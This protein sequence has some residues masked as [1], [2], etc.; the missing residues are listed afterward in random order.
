MAGVFR[1]HNKFHRNSHH[2]LSNTLN[3]DQGSDPIASEIEPFQGIFY[4]ILTDHERTYSIL[5]NSFEWYSVYSTVYSFSAYWDSIG[6]TY[7]TVNAFSSNWGLGYSAY[8]SLNPVSANFESAYTTVKANSAIWGDPNLL[9]TNRAQE[10]TKSKTF[11]GYDLTIKPDGT[12]EWDLDVAQVAFLTL[13][14]SVTV[15]NPFPNT[16]KR[17]GLYTLYVNQDGIGYKNANF[18]QVYKFPVNVVIQNEIN[19]VPYGVSIINFI[20]D[21]NLMFGDIYKTNIVD[22]SPTPT[23]TLTPTPSI[24]PSVTPS[25][26]PSITPTNTVTPSITPTNTVTPSITPTN[27][28]TIS[29]TPTLTPTPTPTLP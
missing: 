26:T 20:C 19:K 23:P 27:T 17:G 5:T 4:N 1:V 7:T 8:L 9:Y 29:V 15:L 14:Q 13:T 28:P 6:T 3:Q 25:I 12:V 10:N 16:M 22:P 2:T 24:T 11:S 18:E 21:G